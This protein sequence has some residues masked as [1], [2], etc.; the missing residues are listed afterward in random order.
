MERV[1]IQRRMDRAQ[2]TVRLGADHIRGQRNFLGRLELYGLEDDAAVARD[3]LR[4]LE[5]ILALRI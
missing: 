4:T 1:G 2:G 3:S 5:G